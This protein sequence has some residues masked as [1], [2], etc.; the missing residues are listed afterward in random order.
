VKRFRF[1]L[2]TVQRVRS[3]QER[4]ALAELARCQLSLAAAGTA[5]NVAQARWDQVADDPGPVTAEV[6]EAITRRMVIQWRGDAVAD[7]HAVVVEAEARHA[8]ARAAYHDARQRLRAIQRL[9]ERRR[10]EYALEAERADRAEADQSVSDRWTRE[11][12][13]S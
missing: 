5:L 11:A 10:S 6:P 3:I 1:R 2:E 8:Q 4:I 7:A 13:G 9:E 12:A